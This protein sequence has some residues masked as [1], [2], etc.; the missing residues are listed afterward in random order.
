MNPHD[1]LKF[2]QSVYCNTSEN[3]FVAKRMLREQI[4]QLKR[5]VFQ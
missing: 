4:E 3:S 5:V 1:L 2:L